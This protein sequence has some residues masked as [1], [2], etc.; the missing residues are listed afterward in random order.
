MK[1]VM[2]GSH[3]IAETVRLCDPKVIAAYPITPQTHIVEKLSEI[4]ADGRMDAEFLTMESEHSAMAACIGAQA[5]GVRTFT[6]TASAGLALM[7]EM[8]GVASGMRL[9]IVMVVAN[10][11]L[12]SPLSIWNDW[13]DSMAEKDMSWIQLYS[14]SNQ[15]AVDNVIQA[16][17]IAEKVKLPVMVCIDG[18]YLSHT[19]EPIDIPE[20]VK[21]FIGD[22]KPDV[23]LDTDNPISMGEYARPDSYQEFKEQ[24][25]DAMEEAKTVIKNVNDSFNK[26][27]G[28]SYGNGLIETYNMENAKHAIITMATISS[29]IKHMINNGEDIGLIRIRS[30]RPFPSEDL[31][32]ITENLESIGVIEKSVS[33]GVGGSL[34]NDVK[35]AINRPI[36]NF[37]AGIGGRDVTIDN[38]KQIINIIKEKK[39]GLYWVASKI[40]DKNGINKK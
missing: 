18:F 32:N 14:E 7:H 30:Y 33:Y 22:Y 24:Q 2:E 9:P 19:Y 40:G 8:L 31:K 5:T 39:Q 15:E 20:N 35:S 21:D 6:A 10:R 29:N 11:A 34:G 23:F 36:S 4:I 38:F 1:N 37:I 25:Y 17:K 26:K 28:R 13:S 27:F 3:A 16:Y 12:S